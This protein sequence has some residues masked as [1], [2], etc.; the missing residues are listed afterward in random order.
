MPFEKW[1]WKV[2]GGELFPV[3]MDLPN[4][5]DSLLKLI[6][7]NRSSDS[8]T[9]RCICRKTGLQCIPACGQC[10]GS[11]CTNFT[12]EYGSEDLEELLE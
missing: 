4:A 1:E 8:S 9:L 3:S 7:C 2:T 10:K 12:V 5:P 6:Q 11:A